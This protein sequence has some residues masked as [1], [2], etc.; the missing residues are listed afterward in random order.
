MEQVYVREIRRFST[1]DGPGVRSVIHLKG[2]FMRCRWCSSPATW[3]SEPEVLIHTTK[4]IRCGACVKICRTGA[5]TMQDGGV[6]YDKNK[7]ERCWACVQVCQQDAAEKT[8]NIMTAEEA[9]E[10]LLKDQMFFEETGGGV[11][12][13]G[14]EP[15][16]HPQFV[17]ELLQLLRENGVHTAIETTANLDWDKIKP[18]IEMVDLMMVDIKHMDCEIHKRLTGVSNRLVLQN[19]ERIADMKKELWIGYPCI[20]GMND[21]R[22]NREAMADFMNRLRLKKLRVFPYHRLGISEYRGLGLQEYVLPL[23]NIP[24]CSEEKLAE[25]KEGFRVCGIDAEIMGME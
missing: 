21:E 3:H 13:S 20:P 22:A 16:M 2:C 7:C 9:A 15:L 18:A 10:Q 14:G 19:I 23:E 4:C 1:Y 12:V 24:Y 17:C 8:G 5:L 11:T 25:I 6:V